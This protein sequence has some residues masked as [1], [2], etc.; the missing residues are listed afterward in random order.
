MQTQRNSKHCRRA[1]AHINIICLDVSIYT[2]KCVFCQAIVL[3]NEFKRCGYLGTNRNSSRR[4][5]GIF[6][7]RTSFSFRYF[8]IHV[9]KRI[10]STYSAIKWVKMMCSNALNSRGKPAVSPMSCSLT[11]NTRKNRN[12][13]NLKLGHALRA[14]EV[15]NN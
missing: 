2:L 13:T 4:S 12:G 14:G 8:G 1:H 11:F 3:E 6:A 7:R 15:I 5:L 10:L 9:K